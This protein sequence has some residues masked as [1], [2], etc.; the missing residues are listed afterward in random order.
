VSTGPSRSESKLAVWRLPPRCPACGLDVMD[1]Q[2]QAEI[3][4]GKAIVKCHAICR[5]NVKALFYGPGKP[6]GEASVS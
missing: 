6:V 2:A 4:W 5:D 3:V 1:A